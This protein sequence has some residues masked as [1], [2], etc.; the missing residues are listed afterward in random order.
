METAF[1]KICRLA[2]EAVVK[3]DMIRHRSRILVGLSGG[4]DS[5][6]LLATLAHLRDKAPVDFSVIGS[7]FDPGYPGFDTSYIG[8]W[9]E[10]Y[11]CDYEVVKL[12]MAAIIK[13]KK[14]ENSPCVLCSRLRRGKLY[15]LAE[16]LN[17]DALALG[18]HL[19]DAIASF[20]MSVCRG[21][22][23]SS[24]GAKV[25]SDA[26]KVLNVIRP[27]IYA[28]EDLVDAAAREL[29]VVPTGKCPFFAEL[30]STGDRQY[31]R[32]LTDRLAER[33]PGVRSNILHSFAVVEADHLPF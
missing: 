1:K 9:C 26:G 21:Q 23:V 2:G 6:V 8:E 10:K 12:D 29:G 15:G 17:C 13:E 4:K 28:S 33:I 7:T 30:E 31:F 11:R 16:K 32:S 20:F 22:G 27:L 18:H 24:M 19:D 14:W 3:H 25:V 5:M